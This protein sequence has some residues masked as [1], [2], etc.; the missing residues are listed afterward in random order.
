M[1]TLENLLNDENMNPLEKAEKIIDALLESEDVT[2]CGEAGAY[3][4]N[5]SGII[6]N[7]RIERN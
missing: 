1:N 7:V 6:Y 5:V 4:E 3:L 2:I